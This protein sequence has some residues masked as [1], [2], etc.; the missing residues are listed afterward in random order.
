[1]LT[2]HTASVSSLCCGIAPGSL[3]L[4]GGTVFR[5]LA[6]HRHSGQQLFCSC[7]CSL[8]LPFLLPLP[9]VPFFPRSTPRP[10]SLHSGLCLTAPP[11]MCLHASTEP[12]MPLSP[13]IFF[14]TTASRAGKRWSCL[15]RGHSV[16]PN[17]CLFGC[18]PIS[19]FYS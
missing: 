14:P 8:G 3:A 5:F 9:R 17:P 10:E 1:M 2:G 16:C 12:V 11:L 15:F 18:S 6:T 4:L 19:F 13:A 7:P